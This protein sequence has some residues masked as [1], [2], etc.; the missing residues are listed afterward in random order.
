MLLPWR[1]FGWKCL[2]FEKQI[3][4]ISLLLNGIYCTAQSTMVVCTFRSH[5]LNL[6][7]YTMYSS[8]SPAI[9]T[10]GC[11]IVHTAYRLKLNANTIVSTVYLHVSTCT[12]VQQDIDSRHAE[13]CCCNR[14]T[15]YIITTVAKSA[16]HLVM[17]MQIFLCLLTV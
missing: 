6:N 3:F 16:R 10:Y 4:F 12:F 11:L 7:Y 13:Y 2:V 5:F 8:G 17:E 9:S 14:F 15:I 1:S